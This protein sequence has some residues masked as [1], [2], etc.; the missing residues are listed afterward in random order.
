MR[1]HGKHD[2]KIELLK[3]KDL[4]SDLGHSALQ[5]MS[6]PQL[7]FVKKFLEEHLK[8]EFIKASSAPCSRPIL[9]VKKPGGGIKFCVDY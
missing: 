3:D 1:P 2:H 7:K 9:L 4:T 6:T 5:G 8:K